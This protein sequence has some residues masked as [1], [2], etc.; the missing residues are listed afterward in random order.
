MIETKEGVVIKGINMSIEEMVIFS[1][2]FGVCSV[3]G[4][5]FCYLL[6]TGIVAV[7]AKIALRYITM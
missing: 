4:I 2:K 7:L 5:V 1:I 6:S 3:P